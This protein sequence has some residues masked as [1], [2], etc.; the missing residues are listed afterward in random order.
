[1]TPL[2][3]QDVIEG[4]FQLFG[5]MLLVLGLPFLLLELISRVKE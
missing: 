2:Y 3:I 5:A 1:M 4:Y